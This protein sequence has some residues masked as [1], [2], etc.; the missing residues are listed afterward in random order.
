MGGG[1]VPDM[2]SEQPYAEAF[3]C[4]DPYA[5]AHLLSLVTA[6]C[7][8]GSLDRFD[9][10]Q[11]FATRF[12]QDV[13]VAGL[14]EQ[15]LAQRL[16]EP[17]DPSPDSGRIDSE[18]PRRGCEQARASQAQKKLKVVPTHGLHYCSYGLH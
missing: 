11:Q 4:A 12:G 2:G 17:P 15:A 13:A 3:R 7:G 5:P 16:F 9:L 1:E 6:D 8:R 10:G 14:L 18:L